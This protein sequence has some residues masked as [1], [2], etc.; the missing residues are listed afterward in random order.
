MSRWTQRATVALLLALPSSADAALVSDAQRVPT[1]NQA[2]DVDAHLS[3]SHAL[4]GDAAGLEGFELEAQL[5]VLRLRVDDP[6]WPDLSPKQLHWHIDQRL[7]IRWLATP[8]ASDHRGTPDDARPPVAPELSFD[9]SGALFLNDAN[10][11]AGPAVRARL[12]LQPGPDGT[13]LGHMAGYLGAGLHARS[14]DAARRRRASLDVFAGVGGVAY[15]LPCSGSS[16]PTS[17]G[18]VDD[19]GD[20]YDDADDDGFGSDGGDGDDVALWSRPPQPRRSTPP[21]DPDPTLTGL[22]GCLRVEGRVPLGRRLELGAGTDLSGF[23]DG[24]APVHARAW[25]ALQLQ[26][27]SSLSVSLHGVWD[28][29]SSEHTTATVVD[30]HP[31]DMGLRR[32]LL[33]ARLG[34][35]WSAW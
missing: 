16:C 35:R 15:L 12:A 18:G 25:A 3:A 27:L 8:L 23:P 32:T 33:Q 19:G 29:L 31:L 22:A 34:L 9:V 10:P 26:L 20:G 24:A 14:Y 13:L 1:L 5:D 7:A 2:L 11:G 4:Q 28:H 21:G 6:R 30:G 17:E